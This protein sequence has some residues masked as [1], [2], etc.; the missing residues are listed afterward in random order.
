MLEQKTVTLVRRLFDRTNAGELGWE[1][2]GETEGFRA[3]LA[4]YGV[5]IARREARDQWGSPLPCYVLSILNQHGRVVEEITAEDLGGSLP[6][7][8][9][10]M[11]SLYEGARRRAMGVEEAFESILNSLESPTSLRPKTASS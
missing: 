1:E 2:A 9:K 3:A 8:E 10:V 6:N 5:L 7:P 11:E 4:N